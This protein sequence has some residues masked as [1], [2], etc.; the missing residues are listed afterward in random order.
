MRGQRATVTEQIL[1]KIAVARQRF[2]EHSYTEIHENPTD[3]LT[4]E[5]TTRAKRLFPA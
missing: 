5:I 2:I 4:A 1:R 3:I